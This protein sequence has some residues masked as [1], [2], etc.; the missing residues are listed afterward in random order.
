MLKKILILGGA[1]VHCKLVEAA[2]EMNLYV[3]VTDYL[4]KDESP[5]KLIADKSYDIDINDTQ[6]I[7]RVCREEGIDG[8]LTTHLDPCQKPYQKICR[9][10]GLPCFGTERQFEYLTNKHMFKKI[11]RKYGVDIIPEYTEEDI[12]EDR[13]AY[14]VFVKPVDSRGSRGQRKCENKE[15]TLEAIKI[16]GAES[17]NGDFIIE[18][19][20]GD[21]EEIQ[22]TYFFINGTPCLIRTT[23]SFHGSGKMRNVITHSVSPSR[24]T[25]ELKADTHEK[26]VKMLKEIGIMNGPVM[27]QG[28]Y[29]DG[30]FRVFDPGL[31]FP[32]VDYERIYK[33]EYKIDLLKL[34]LEYSLTGSMPQVVLDED[35]VFLNGKQAGI[36]F[37]L[38]SAGTIKK[39]EGFTE[40]KEDTRV[41]SILPRHKEGDN[42]KWTYDINQR[43][44]E[45][46]ILFEKQ[47]ASEVLE[48][49]FTNLKVLD[50][51]GKNMLLNRC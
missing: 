51:N 32:G 44:C 11:C 8:V 2:H 29:D 6:E 28:F 12:Y 50:K 10:L 48:E 15:Q 13:V 41:I 25:M 17:S 37:P 47:N 46:D 7:V 3:I 16:A 21:K 14:P 26:I 45:I 36:L 20:L 22:V 27:M 24:Y 42:V 1:Q 49:I 34:M 31:R 33:K 40:L 35:S 9:E 30:I 5:A 23:D 18:K 43:L 19:Y 4:K 39:I 38:I